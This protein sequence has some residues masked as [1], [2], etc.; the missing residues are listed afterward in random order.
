MSLL[1]GECF[2]T[3]LLSLTN[4]LLHC[5]LPAW[6]PRCIASGRT[7]QKTPPQQSLCCY[8][9][10]PSDSGDIDVFTGHYQAM[11]VPSHRHCLAMVLHATVSL[12]CFHV[13]K[14]SSH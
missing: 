3:E 5:T 12:N 8:G 14:K 11:H 10:L 4:Q 6:G 1:S 7:Q 9:L 2:T 13:T